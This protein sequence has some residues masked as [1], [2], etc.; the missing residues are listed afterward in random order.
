MRSAVLRRLVAPI[1]TLALVA[2]GEENLG[3]V[4]PSIRVVA[5]HRDEAGNR[6]IDFGPV[7]VLITEKRALLVSNEG[8]APLTLRALTI[9][10]DDDAFRSEAVSEPV[11][12]RPGEERE[13]EVAFQPPAEAEF[14][15]VLVLEHDDPDDPPIEVG[16]VGTGSTVGRAEVE[17]RTVDFGRVGE[18]TMET[19]TVYVRSVGTARL[20]VESIEL[21]GAPEFSIL[22]STSTPVDLPPPTGGAAGGEIALVIAC[23]PGPDTGDEPMEGTLTLRTTD[24]E[25]REVVIGLSA[26]VNRAPIARIEPT[27][28]VPAPGDAIPLD[29][30]ASGDP[31]GDEPIAFAWRIHRMPFGSNARIEGADTATPTLVTDVAG[32]YVV[33][34]DVADATGLSCLHP[35]GNPNV[36]CTTREVVVKPADDLVFEVVWD[37]DRTD[38]DIHL[39]VS[40]AELYSGRDCYYGNP[41]PDFGTIGDGTDDPRLTRDVLAGFGPERIVYSDP[42]EGSFDLVVV[43]AKTNGAAD[44]LTRATVRV[45]VY[46]ILAAELTREMS[47]P[48]E[49]WDAL[50]IEWPSATITPLEDPAVQ[51]HPAP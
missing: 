24:P 31:D 35:Q 16:L 5:T 45:Y 8:M 34:L 41:N 12:L 19:R 42:P 14:S 33:G 29:G 38:L 15:G 4:E 28:G 27:S 39:L 3:Q 25:N 46:G 2:C 21:A 51:E 26:T 13:L 48:D 30:S 11:V 22:G 1:A 9:T 10:A 7:P 17:P 20:V 49:R 23:A 36:P 37:H 50:T 44:P 32:S 43:F 40:G 47:F 6:L 18:G